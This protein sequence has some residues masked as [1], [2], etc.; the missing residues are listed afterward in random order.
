VRKIDKQKSFQLYLPSLQA[1]I[2]PALQQARITPIN[3][4]MIDVLDEFGICL[5]GKMKMHL[6][7]KS[8]IIISHP[9]FNFLIKP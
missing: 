1:T 7:T 3:P 4:D 5:W 2:I 6:G 8:S 9:I